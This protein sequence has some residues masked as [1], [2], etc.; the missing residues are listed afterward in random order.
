MTTTGK[1]KSGK[2]E[3]TPWYTGDLF[4]G[5]VH[6]GNPCV[7][8]GPTVVICGL[9]TVQE[10]GSRT[11][12]LLKGQLHTGQSC[13]DCLVSPRTYQSPLHNKKRKRPIKRA[14]WLFGV[15]YCFQDH[16]PFSSGSLA[17]L[18]S[19][20]IERLLRARRL[21]GISGS[22]G[23]PDRA[24]FHGATGNDCLHLPSQMSTTQASHL[25]PP[26]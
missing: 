4:K 1:S 5:Q 11:P 16:R 18:W 26:Q 20:L 25:F 21:C 8:R 23:C 17:F 22:G 3:R 13:F 6:G 9:S 2:R 12:M 24:A 15:P 7:C 14:S 19:W 10:V